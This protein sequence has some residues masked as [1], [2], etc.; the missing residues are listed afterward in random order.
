MNP[1]FRLS[2]ALSRLGKF[3]FPVHLFD[4]SRSYLESSASLE[5]GQDGEDMKRLV[6]NPQDPDVIARLSATPRFNAVLRTTCTATQLS[7]GHAGNALPQMASAT[8]NCRILPVEKPDDIQK[9][10]EGV[11]AD[12]TIK[13]SRLAEPLMAQQKPM[14]PKVVGIVKNASQKVWPGRR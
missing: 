6:Q 1:I 4:V 8:V 11:L 3:E 10:L 12:P 13:V 7:G 5:G 9:T 14:D 2:D